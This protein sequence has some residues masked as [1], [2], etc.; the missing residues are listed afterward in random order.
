MV[1]AMVCL[2]GQST[3]ARQEREMIS[4]ERWEKVEVRGDSYIE[5]V[6]QLDA[7]GGTHDQEGIACRARERGATSM[8]SAEDCHRSLQPMPLRE[9]QILMDGRPAPTGKPQPTATQLAQAM[10]IY[11][12]YSTVKN[13]GRDQLLRELRLLCGGVYVWGG[14][15][16]PPEY[17]MVD[18]PDAPP[19]PP[20]YVERVIEKSPTIVI[21]YPQP[22]P[23]QVRYVRTAYV[24]QPM[25]LLREERRYSCPPRRQFD[26][27]RCFDRV[28]DVGF[29]F[30]GGYG[31]GHSRGGSPRRS[32]RE[33]QRSPNISFVNRNHNIN[34]NRNTNGNMN[35]NYSRR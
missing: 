22:V 6:S 12:R 11:T 15:H 32:Y 35:G 26:W 30:L 21:N 29:R 31:G 25:H 5:A 9:L 3:Q 7:Q 19:P 13:L 18:I 16:I 20:Q 2:F 17:R 24:R 28:M 10:E 4:R 27:G 33:H 14:R 8:A 23:E 1:C 34:V